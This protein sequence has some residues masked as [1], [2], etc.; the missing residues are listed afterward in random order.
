[1]GSLSLYDLLV[2]YFATEGG[3]PVDADRDAFRRLSEEQ[4]LHQSILEN[5]SM[6]LRTRQ[7]EPVVARLDEERLQAIAEITHGRYHGLTVDDADVRYL[8]A[9][10]TLDPDATRQTDRRFDL[11]ADQGF[12][13]AIVLLP[14][15]L[16]GFRRGVFLLLPLLILPAPADA[17]IWEDLWLRRDQQ[18]YRELQEG[19]P[20]TVLY[21]RELFDAMVWVEVMDADGRVGWIPEVYLVRETPTPTVAP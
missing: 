17:G 10:P 14:L 6:I 18:A 13:L 21:G 7:G 2:G 11:W 1:M 5:L 20:I 4:K 12:W 3:E 8:L 15:L 9:T 16:L 19:Q